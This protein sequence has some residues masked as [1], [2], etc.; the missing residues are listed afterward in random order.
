ME[1]ERVQLEQCL[2]GLLPDQQ[3]NIIQFISC[4]NQEGVSTIVQ[5][6]GRILV[7]NQG[8]SV[9][10]VDGRQPICLGRH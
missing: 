8:K 9:L 1:R 2:A 10:L 4:R 7:E 3:L 5:E 6:L